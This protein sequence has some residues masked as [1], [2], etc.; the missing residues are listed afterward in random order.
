MI[1]ALCVIGRSC[2]C[3]DAGACNSNRCA[4]HCGTDFD[5]GGNDTRRRIGHT[6]YGTAIAKKGEP[7]GEKKLTHQVISRGAEI[8]PGENSSLSID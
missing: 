5:R 6:D 3:L 4:D 7:D 8:N 1:A 2:N